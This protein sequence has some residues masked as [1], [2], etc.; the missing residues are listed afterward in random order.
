MNQK[1]KQKIKDGD[2]EAFR[3]FWF[4][5]PTEDEF[6]DVMT[7]GVITARNMYIMLTYPINYRKLSNRRRL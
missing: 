3:E 4:S 5:H 6:V 2:E 1:L 7:E